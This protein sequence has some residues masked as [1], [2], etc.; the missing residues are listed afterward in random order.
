MAVRQRRVFSVV[1]EVPRILT[2]GAWCH[3]ITPVAKKG[4]IDRSIDRAAG[5][6]HILAALAVPL[7][8][9]G[10]HV[11]AAHF[12]PLAALGTAFSDAAPSL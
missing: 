1:Q 12:P 7:P 11:H 5:K 8:H 3:I 9:L 10:C 2:R 4:L 6:V